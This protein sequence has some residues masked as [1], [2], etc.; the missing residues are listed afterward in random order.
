MYF[1]KVNAFEYI[2][3]QISSMSMRQIPKQLPCFHFGTRGKQQT[4]LGPKKGCAHYIS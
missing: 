3:N 2:T 1:L 4:R